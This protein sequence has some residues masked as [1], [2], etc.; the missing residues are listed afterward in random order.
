MPRTASRARHRQPHCK[1]IE[2]FAM[3]SP[4]SQTEASLALVCQPPSSSVAPIPTERGRR[5]NHHLH[6]SANG[7]FK[8]F[9][10]NILDS[11]CTMQLTSLPWL[12]FPITLQLFSFR[13]TFSSSN[14]QCPR[15]RAES[16]VLHT[17]RRSEWHRS[18]PGACQGQCRG[19]TQNIYKTKV[20]RA[21][22]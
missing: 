6:G 15:C 18:E 21:L 1:N 9:Q 8:E 12:Y 17:A 20:H 22:L 2:S 4:D 19:R 14:L 16:P 11:H 5:H 13:Q 7:A 3:K 10:D